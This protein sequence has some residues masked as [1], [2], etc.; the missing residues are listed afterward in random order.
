MLV[1]S[2]KRER[3]EEEAKKKKR[4]RRRRRRRSWEDGYCKTRNKTNPLQ[5]KRQ[6]K[7]SYALLSLSLSLS[8]VSLREC[9]KHPSL[10]H[11]ITNYISI[12]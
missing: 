5:L 11:I 6:D 9:V 1:T 8:L 4:R 12:L 10:W 7:E 3:E 2:A